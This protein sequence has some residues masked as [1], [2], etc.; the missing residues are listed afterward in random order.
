VVHI[1]ITILGME[2]RNKKLSVSS[3][4]TEDTQ[5]ISR[6]TDTVARWSRI[7]LLVV[8]NDMGIWETV[9]ASYFYCGVKCQRLYSVLT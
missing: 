5:Y 9:T 3:A 6:S 1:I 2:S 8:S 4:V 7:C